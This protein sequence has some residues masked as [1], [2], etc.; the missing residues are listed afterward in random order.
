MVISNS[1][2]LTDKKLAPQAQ[3]GHQ[4]IITLA[5]YSSPKT[6]F[7]PSDILNFLFPTMEATGFL[8]DAVY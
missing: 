5:P 3:S 4:L 1:P 6:D 8:Y 2:L 7:L